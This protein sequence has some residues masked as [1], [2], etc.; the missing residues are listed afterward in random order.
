VDEPAAL[1]HGGSRDADP[2]LGYLRL[3]FEK[4]RIAPAQVFLG[5]KRDWWARVITNRRSS[6]SAESLKRFLKGGRDTRSLKHGEEG[7]ED[8]GL[9][10]RGFNS[11]RVALRTLTGAEAP[12]NRRDLREPRERLREVDTRSSEMFAFPSRVRTSIRSR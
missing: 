9:A 2:M 12:P 3:R 1:S 10:E 4:S 5:V 7:Q 6:D 8:L 11:A